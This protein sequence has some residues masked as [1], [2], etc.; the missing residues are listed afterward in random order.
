M[1]NL[2]TTDK[3]MHGIPDEIVYAMMLAMTVSVLLIIASTFVASATGTRADAH[4]LWP[5][6]RR[7]SMNTSEHDR[8]TSVDMIAPYMLATIHCD[9]NHQ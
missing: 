4:S 3:I 5:L 8:M 2:K 1:I 6:R 7:H 9:W